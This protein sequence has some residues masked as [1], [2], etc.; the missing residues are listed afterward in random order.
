[1]PNWLIDQDLNVNTINEEITSM[2]LKYKNRM[3]NHPNTMA[4]KLLKKHEIE[5]LKKSAHSMNYYSFSFI[6]MYLFIFLFI[7]Y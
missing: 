3:E 4:R 6:H 2:N 1:M 5:G 7:F